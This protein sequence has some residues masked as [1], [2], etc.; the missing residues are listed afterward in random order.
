MKENLKE[1]ILI[2]PDAIQE[3]LDHIQE[4]EKIITIPN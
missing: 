2:N 4:I 3:L 1:K